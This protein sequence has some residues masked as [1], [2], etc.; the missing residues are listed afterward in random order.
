MPGGKASKQAGTATPWQ[1]EHTI[2]RAFLKPNKNCPVL[3]TIALNQ[4]RGRRRI[5]AVFR[6]ALQPDA[7]PRS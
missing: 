4:A 2:C 6:H 3:R 1:V 7:T 5:V